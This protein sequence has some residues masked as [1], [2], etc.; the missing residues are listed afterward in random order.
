MQASPNTRHIFGK[1]GDNPHLAR[2]FSRFMPEL[3]INASGNGKSSLPWPCK[4]TKRP[5]VFPVFLPFSGC[6]TR[7][8]FC[9]QPAQTGTPSPAGPAGCGPFWLPRKKPWP[10]QTKNSLS[11]SPF[12]AAHSRPRTG[13]PCGFALI[14]P[15]KCFGR[16]KSS[17]FAAQQG[18][19]A[20]T[21]PSLPN[22][23][24]AA[25]P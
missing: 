23:S 20:W 5:D 22:S 17:P 7:C 18:Q 1:L 19:I 3:T 8:V 16:A 15:K 21:M 6:R 24:P 11:S 2:I 10:R 14:L 25:A 4:H 12:M 13:N 9:S